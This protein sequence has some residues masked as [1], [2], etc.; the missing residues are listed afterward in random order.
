MASTVTSCNQL[1]AA[2]SLSGQRPAA[3]VFPVLLMDEAAIL[4]RVTK[5]LK[6]WMGRLTSKGAMLP[7]PLEKGGAESEIA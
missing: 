2:R 7:S 1:F 4:L 3:E 6:R 5:D